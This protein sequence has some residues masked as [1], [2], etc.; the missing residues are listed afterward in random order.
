MALNQLTG[1]LSN[2]GN[3]IIGNVKKATL[4]LHDLQ[5]GVGDN[6]GALTGGGALTKSTQKILTKAASSSNSSVLDTMSD[7]LSGR[8]GALEVQYNPSS[9]SLQANAQRVS[10]SY[11]LKNMDEGIPNQS[12]R[13]PSVTLS[14]QLVFDDTN[15]K[16]AFMADKLRLSAGDIITDAG[17][18]AKAVRGEVY[19]VQPQTNG[20]VAMLMRDST[21]LVTFQWADMSFTGQVCQ[22][23]ARY[24]M[25]SFS[26]QPIRS[27]V[28]LVILQ[29]I[30][31]SGD[32]RQW[33]AA[34]DKC[35]GDSLNG[36]LTGLQKAG[37]ALQNSK[38]LINLN[39]L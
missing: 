32:Q 35:F 7:V 30:T 36:N 21:R 34:F 6:M 18:I 27:V 29:E 2:V 37:N 15:V 39:L 22:V 26:G 12:T 23:Q 14:V 8:G 11:L 1:A 24:T 5:S 38:N 3:S 28:D 9:L 31:G 16:D 20:L 10:V 19:S 17:A 4:L 13:P 33:D 25:F